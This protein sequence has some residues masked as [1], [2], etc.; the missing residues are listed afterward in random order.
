[1]TDNERKETGQSNSIA[2][3]SSEIFDAYKQGALKVIE[4]LL[5]FNHNM[6]K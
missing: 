6:Y 2:Q 5:N 4:G 1:M 3:D